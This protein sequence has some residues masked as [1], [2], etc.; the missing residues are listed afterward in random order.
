LVQNPSLVFGD[1]LTINSNNNFLGSGF[2]RQRTRVDKDASLHT[3]AVTVDI[4]KHPS[5]NYHK[6]EAERNKDTKSDESVHI[7]VV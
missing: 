5:G 7:S 1:F 3:E 6:G 2:N 4:Q